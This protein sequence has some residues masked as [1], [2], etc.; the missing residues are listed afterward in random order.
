MYDMMICTLIRR[1]VLQ[2]FMYKR[3]LHIKTFKRHSGITL[4]TQTCFAKVNCNIVFY[5]VTFYISL[6][7]FLTTTGAFFV[8]V[9]STSNNPV[10]VTA[11]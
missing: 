1:N 2:I 5:N 10:H 9:I 11:L 7:I 4:L 3:E 8:F 6:F